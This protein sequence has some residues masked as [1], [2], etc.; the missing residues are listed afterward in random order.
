M[1]EGRK[2][3]KCC[4]LSRALY[5]VASSIGR[6]DY[7]YLSSA[8][9][10]WFLKKKL[11]SK[12]NL[13]D[14]DRYYGRSGRS[15]NGQSFTVYYTPLH[16]AVTQGSLE[17]VQLLCGAGADKSKKIKTSSDIKKEDRATES[18]NLSVMWI[19]YLRAMEPEQA[20]AEIQQFRSAAFVDLSATELAEKLMKKKDDF[21]PSEKRKAIYEFLNAQ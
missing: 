10:I 4:D 15:I 5:A 8:N 19:S 14:F 7:L 13:N 21:V 1:Q 6:N 9:S 20:Q 11:E 17:C 18:E 12:E 16:E 3:S 2:T